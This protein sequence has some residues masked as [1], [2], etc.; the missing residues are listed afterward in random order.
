M[1]YA[2][3]LFAES[4]HYFGLF[5]LTGARSYLRMALYLHDQAM[6]A[7]RRAHFQPPSADGGLYVTL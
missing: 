7:E 3:R 2:N 1:R 4:K 6:A 5:F